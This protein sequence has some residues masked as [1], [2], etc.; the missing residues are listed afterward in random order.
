M[1]QVHLFAPARCDR[2]Y[3]ESCS[4]S[5]GQMPSRCGPCE[6]KLTTL[7]RIE[8]PWR[9]SKSRKTPDEV[10]NG[11]KRQRSGER[12]SP[13]GLTEIGEDIEYQVFYVS[14]RIVRPE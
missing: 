10:R 4:T 12:P 2:P 14:C 1:A 13:S 7:L 6:S 8:S 11:P 5:Y 3:S 9:Y